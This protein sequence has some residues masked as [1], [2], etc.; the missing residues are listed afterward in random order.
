MS[1]TTE[2][3][4]V[5]HRQNALLRAERWTAAGGKAIVAKNER[6][7]YRYAISDGRLDNSRVNPTHVV[8][9]HIIAGVAF[10]ARREDDKHDADYLERY[11]AIASELDQLEFDETEERLS[12]LRELGFLARIDS[13]DETDYNIV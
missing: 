8:E 2:Q 5:S 9:A 1:T 3:K 4:L 6:G 13:F 11:D 10:M 7:R 12:T